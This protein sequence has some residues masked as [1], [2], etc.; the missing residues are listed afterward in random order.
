MTP[1]THR[2][3][4]KS[5]EA[6][7]GQISRAD[8]EAAAKAKA[9]ASASEGG[10][11]A[12]AAAGEEEGED[13]E[14]GEALTAPLEEAFMSRTEEGEVSTTVLGGGGEC[15]NSSVAVLFFVCFG[16]CCSAVV[17]CQLVH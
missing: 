3:N 9:A 6:R 10:A 17:G 14:M 13:A 4:Y 15:Q 5:L 11:D 7:L 1:D 12:A 8:K 2:E 16:F